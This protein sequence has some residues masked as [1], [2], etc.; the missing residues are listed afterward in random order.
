[1]LLNY[2]LGISIPFIAGI[3]VIIL[4]AWL[5][6]KMRKKAVAGETVGFFVGLIV[7]AFLF[8][9][10]TTVYVLSGDSD[11]VKY[12]SFGNSS[13][14]LEDGKEVGIDSSIGYCT[15]INDSDD[16]FVLE[17]VIYGNGFEE[18][19]FV[20]PGFALKVDDSAIDYFFNEMPPETIE[21]SGSGSY[22]VRLWL[23][24]GATYMADYGD[25]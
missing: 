10:P 25:Q 19:K 22:A 2:Y 13:Y 12:I 5:W 21:T 6:K 15:V 14:T 24:T 11:F 17:H 3:A 8:V 16:N 1:M 4:F 7:T 20:G 18:D 9:M 23:R